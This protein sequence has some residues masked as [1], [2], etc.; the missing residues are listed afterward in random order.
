MNSSNFSIS[1]LKELGASSIS[2]LNQW[3]TSREAMQKHLKDEEENQKKEEAKLKRIQQRP[4]SKLQ[5]AA[6]LL[7][8]QDPRFS[9]IHRKFPHVLP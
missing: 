7:I 6:V 4:G 9:M 8:G 1:M 5:S 3:K 2:N